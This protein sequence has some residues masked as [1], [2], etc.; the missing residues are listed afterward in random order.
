MA[1]KKEIH[2]SLYCDESTHIELHVP[3]EPLAY[4]DYMGLLL[5]PEERSEELLSLLLNARCLN[6]SNDIWL[7]CR[8]PCKYHKQNNTEI[9]YKELNKSAKYN[10]ACSWIE[11]LLQQTQR[12]DHP[13][14]FYILG[15][16]RSKLDLARFGPIEQQNR[17][18][19]IYNRFFRTAIQKSAKSFFSD[20]DQITI[21]NI[22]HDQG[23][24]ENHP[25]F[26]WQS[27]WHL[28]RND[29][30]LHFL[31]DEI[32]FI[33]SD[34]RADD[35]D[36]KHSQFVQFIDLILGC[37]VNILHNNS[38]NEHKKYISLKAKPLLGDRIIQKPSNPNS[39]YYYFRKQRIEFFPHYDL[40]SFEEGSLLAKM[41]Q[42]DNFYTNRPLLIKDTYQD[43]LL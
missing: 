38:T 35:G 13:I 36:A 40:S 26:P 12:G 41:R 6:T 42:L 18:I 39:R 15:I 37:T 23:S 14:Y 7:G 4:W 17:D 21:D 30:K 28:E 24:G 43:R 5:V 1:A 29:P 16:D 27:I 8:N 11:M 20:F 19:T 32:T 31:K 33:N 22:Y 2:L 3:G 34:H 10:V 25:Y 9:H